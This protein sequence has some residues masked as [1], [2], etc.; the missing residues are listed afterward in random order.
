MKANAFRTAAAL[1]HEYFCRQDVAFYNHCVKGSGPTLAVEVALLFLR[2]V[3]DHDVEDQRK[4]SHC[5]LARQ[6]IDVAARP[7]AAEC[8]FRDVDEA[9][10]E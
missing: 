2:A 4:M 9:S 6:Y 3:V 1:L 8:H 10:V 7:V 5:R